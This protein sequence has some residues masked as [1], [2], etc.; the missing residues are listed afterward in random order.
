MR[1]Q[2]ISGIAVAA[3]LG[4]M[5]GGGHAQSLRGSPASIDRM[6]GQAHDHNLTFFRSGTGVR[7]AAR[8]DDLVRLSGNENYRVVNVTYPYALSTT[9]TFVQRLSAQ[10]R[11]ACG[12]R[13]VVTSA[14][15]PTSLRL[16]NSTDKSVHPTG[17]AVD[18][19]KPTR[20]SCLRWLRGTLLALEE[21]G[22]IEATEEHRPPHF[23][24]AVYPRQYLAYIGK[25]PSE[26]LAESSKPRQGR[27]TY[28]VRRGDSLWAIARRH[29]TSVER[30]KA[31]NDM[32]STRVVAGQ[33]L[34]IPGGR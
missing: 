26:R 1:I 2:R 17:M 21:R 7:S 15:R 12:E 9:R 18:I 13:L 25:K 32:R 23:H 10:Y 8:R 6:Y 29:N 19:R 20:G 16:F 31:A 22:A 4:L 5:A 3:A 14:T 33:V 24:V 11:D 27:V 30:L 34:V 28:R